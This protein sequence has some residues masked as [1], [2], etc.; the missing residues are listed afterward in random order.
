KLDQFQDSTVRISE[1]NESRFADGEVEFLWLREKLYPFGLEVLV[2]LLQIL[3]FEGD[4]GDASVV[5]MRIGFPLSLGVFPFNQI[6]AGGVRIVTEHEQRGATAA[7]GDFQSG[8][9]LWVAAF[10]EIGHHFESQHL[11]ECQRTFEI[12]DINVDMKNALDHPLPSL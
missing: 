9:K 4:P 12:G 8:V 7:L 10:F 1:A 11:V 5:Q 6:D 3:G 2:D